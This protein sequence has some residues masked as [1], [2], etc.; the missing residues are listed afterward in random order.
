MGGLVVSFIIFSFFLKVISDLTIEKHK[1][2]TIETLDLIVSDIN[3]ICE[4]HTLGSISKM[5]SL[6][7]LVR[8]IYVSDTGDDNTENHVSSGNNICINFMDYSGCQTI[9]C[10]IELTSHVKEETLIS[11]IDRISGKFNYREYN[12][13]I[14]KEDGNVKVSIS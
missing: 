4:T 3:S 8:V 1:Q 10:P 5:I 2:N 12:L 6:S 11:L 7:D 9:S 14:L 13:E